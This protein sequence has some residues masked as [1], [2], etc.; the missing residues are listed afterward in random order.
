MTQQEQTPSPNLQETPK[1]R[2]RTGRKRTHFQV[3]KHFPTP[4]R[5]L[6]D[7]ATQQEQQTAHQIVVGIL[8]W[9]LGKSSKA[10]ICERL[11]QP[12]LRMWQLSQQ[13]LAGM[14]AGVLKQPRTRGK[15]GLPTMDPKDDPKMLKKENEE[16]RRRLALTEKLNEIL[17][18]LPGNQQRGTATRRKKTKAQSRPASRKK[19]KLPPTET[20]PPD[21]SQ[22][23]G[24]G[25]SSPESEPERR[26]SDS[27]PGA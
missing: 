7:A 6:W 26:P 27:G 22:G 19:P 12:P 23:T 13:A 5:G 15:G 3:P 20:S 10:E 25:V 18:E 4:V 16:L 11:D 8:E 24:G 17:R 2:R 1:K 9:W 14:L 21:R